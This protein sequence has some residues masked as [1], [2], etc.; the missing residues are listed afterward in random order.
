MDPVEE[1]TELL[2]AAGAGDADAMD[3]VFASVY[4]RLRR[5]ARG[6]RRSWHGNP[7]LDTTALVHEAYL[8][9]ARRSSTRFR[10]R[11]HFFAVAAKAMRQLLIDYAEKK[12]AAKRGGGEAP[13][14]LEEERVGAGEDAPEGAV[15]ELLSLNAALERL[16]E[17]EP[18]Q[19]R[20]VE[21]LFFLGLT[22]DETAETLDVSPATVK[23]DWSAAK[24]WLYREMHPAG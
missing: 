12:R 22:I 6:R 21:C 24:A 13:E 1:I 9:I 15:L 4:P 17:L 7:T 14:T 20:V 16:E 2:Q 8:K 23:R 5:I 10:N 18:R 19:G 3:D 11:G